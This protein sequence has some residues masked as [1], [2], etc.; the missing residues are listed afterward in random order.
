[1]FYI[2]VILGLVFAG[3][4]LS[5]LVGLKLVIAEFEKWGYSSQFRLLVG[6]YELIGAALLL[7]PAT[8]IIGLWWFVPLM[9]GAMYTHLKTPGDRP[10]IVLPVVVLAALFLLLLNRQA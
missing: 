6:V 9:L 8:A 2:R 1:M 3:S 5:K 7:V 10:R 4:G